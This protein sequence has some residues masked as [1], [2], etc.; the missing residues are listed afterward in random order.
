MAGFWGR[1]GGTMTKRAPVRIVFTKPRLVALAPKAERYWVLDAKTP[2][3]AVMV[4]PRGAKSYYF[5][6]KAHGRFERVRIA[7]VGELSVEKARKRVAIL[8]G[9]V[10]DG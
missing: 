1:R 9:D 7:S 6:K 2:R 8:G 3:L 5:V 4:T 10:A